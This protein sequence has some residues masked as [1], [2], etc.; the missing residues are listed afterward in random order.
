MASP[1]SSSAHQAL[2][3]QVL[4]AL[5]VPVLACD[6]DGRVVFANPAAC[7]LIGRAPATLIGTDLAALVPARL[8]ALDGEPLH[9][10]LV[11]R[12]ECGERTGYRMA[13]LRGDVEIEVE[14]AVALADRSLLVLSL[15]VI[16]DAAERRGRSG[17]DR[18]I[19][20]HAP[21]GLFHFDERGV[22]TDCNEN[23]VAIIGSTRRVLVGLNMMTLPDANMV[24]CV[25]AALA[26]ELSG[27]EGE[28]RSATARKVTPVSVLFAPIVEDG[29]I[30]GGVGIVRDDS[31]RTAAMEALSLSE[32][33]FRAVTESAPDAIAV[34]RDGRTVY[35]N[36]TL[37]RA[38][39][40]ADASAVRDRPIA[41]LIHADDL[42]LLPRT[43]A[44]ADRTPGLVVLRWLRSDGRVIETEAATVDVTFD[45]A[46]AVAVVARDVTETHALRARLAQADRLAALGTL[47]AGVAHEINNPLAYLMASIETALRAVTRPNPI[48][49]EPLLERALDGAQRVRRIVQDLR[50]FSRREET[51]PLPV[52]VHSVLDAAIN[53]C[54]GEIKHRAHLDRRYGGIPPVRGDEVRLGQVFVNLLVN[55]A[56]A[57]PDDGREHTIRVATLTRDGRVVIE[58]A[59]DGVGI[60]PELLPRVFEPFVTTKPVGV[61]T[62]LG[63]SICHG[64]VSALGG[65]ITL[66]SHLGRGTI[67][68]VCLPVATAAEQAAA[69]AEP[70]PCVTPARI[71]IVDDE[72]NLVESLQLELGERH[73][74]TVATTGPEALRI[75][76]AD[77]DFDLVL[78]DVMMSGTSG[79]ELFHAARRARPELASRFAFMTGGVLSSDTF[80]ALSATGRPRLDKPFTVRQLEQLLPT[81]VSAAAAAAR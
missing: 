65:D 62:G 75:L 49:I 51:R 71:L 11:G 74:V 27:Y 36:P 16:Q 69:C 45:G 68:R 67:V 14:C 9:R 40:H 37:A 81:L 66:E 19:F 12:A 64:L 30:T 4:T 32:S 55:A 70:V 28:Y 46:A 50:L 20:E 79:L 33:S 58:I 15:S 18:L 73:Q 22:I 39:G 34:V 47:A 26:G 38:L 1:E 59:D 13:L 48:R 2:P 29:R 57:I 43:V 23:F 54:W 6:P 42:D 53:I 8:R 21:L 80:Q 3:V 72:A 31:E 63:L 35:A 5:P 60:P 56:Q 24:R 41:E 10:L 44:D 61:G 52:D 25:R 78:C 17:S 76:L 77:P 7:Q